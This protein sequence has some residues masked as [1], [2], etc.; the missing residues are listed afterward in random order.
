MF[1]VGRTEDLPCVGS[2]RA[3]EPLEVHTGDHV[4][5]LSVAVFRPHLGVKGLEARRQDDGPYIDLFLLGRLGQIDGVVLTDGFADAAFLL[6]QIE[7]AFID[8]GDQGN[9]LGKI[10]VDRLIE[11]YFLVVLIRVLDGAVFHADG[12]PCAFILPDIPGFSHQ[13]YVKV[14]C[15]PLYTVN[16]RIGEDFYVGMPADLDQFGCEYSHGAVI[17]RKGLVELGHMA[18]YA[19]GLFHQVHLETGGGKIER[20]LDA[21]DPSANNHDISEIILSEIVTQ[22]LNVLC[23]R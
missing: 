3:E 1:P 18:A 6:F 9:R 7:T 22:L 12:T 11:G 17:G 16:F 19:R 10:D 15:F 13:C 2:G 23:N 14:S 4:L 5:E 8:V 20:G 21:A